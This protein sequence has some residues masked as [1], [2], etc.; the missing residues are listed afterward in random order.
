MKA[1]R[2]E[3]EQRISDM[4]VLIASAENELAL[5]KKETGESLQPWA[6]TS[7][8]STE[9]LQILVKIKHTVSKPR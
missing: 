9:G 5:L 8:R 1:Q 3:R 4:K 7:P 6:R 2:D